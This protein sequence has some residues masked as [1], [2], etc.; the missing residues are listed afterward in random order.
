MALV[1]TTQQPSCKINGVDLRTFGIELTKMPGILLPEIIELRRV[2][3]EQAGSR[4]LGS[5]YGNIP[6]TLDFQVRGLTHID[7]R[8]KLDE[9]INWID[10]SQYYMGGFAPARHPIGNLYFELSGHKYGYTESTIAV[11]QGNKDI[12]GSGTQWLKFVEEGTRFNIQD[13]TTNYII[14]QV[15]EDT[16]IVLNTGV[17]RTSDSGLSYN[18]ERK[19]YLKCNYNGTSSIGG[20]TRAYFADNV[21]NLSLSMLSPY[22]YW[23]GHPVFSSNS[24]VAANSF[25]TLDGVGNAAFS[26]YS[27][28]IEGAV[29][30]PKIVAANYA[31]TCK[32]NGSLKARNIFNQDQN[33][34]TSSLDSYQQTRTGL[35]ILCDSGSEHIE[36]TSLIGNP[37]QIGILVRIYPQFAYDGAAS[38]K[39]ILEYRYDANNYVK[40]WY[41]HTNYMFKITWCGASSAVTVASS[42][43]S[44][45]SDDEIEIMFSLGTSKFQDS[46][47]YS[48]MYI[49]GNL[50]NSNT[51][52]SFTEMDDNPITLTIG[53]DNAHAEV[54]ECIIDELQILTS[55]SSASDLKVWRN[56][57]NNNKVLNT[58]GMFEYKGSL[59]AD[60]IM[61]V[62]CGDGKS[63]IYDYDTNTVVYPTGE[64]EGR[65]TSIKGD[66]DEKQVLFIPNA[67]DRLDIHY[68]AHW[69]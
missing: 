7:F 12:T 60:D 20:I 33:P 41:D 46:T 59:G 34:A 45:A 27:I 21:Y 30:N 37:E 62:H 51:S 22:P 43:Q 38:T 17:V 26:D 23:V 66:L 32:F 1:P 50:E 69:R 56:S 65:V 36:Y 4:D 24:S 64:L 9:L 54:S 14:D 39:T 47:Y 5:Y 61:A 52:S 6:F 2:V 29:T 15:G 16:T 10:V 40:L 13:D 44:F 58:N 11:V 68:R 25:I 35:G 57:N 63:Y 18:A 19:R 53:S 42:A 48:L 28:F 8:N 31:F 49:N 55:P 3:E 67:L